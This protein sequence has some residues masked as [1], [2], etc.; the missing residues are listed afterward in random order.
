MIMFSRALASA[1]IVL[2]AAIPAVAQDDV[3]TFNAFAVVTANGTIVR[4]AEKQVMVVAT[5]AGPYFVE[6]DEG[7]QHG[8]R[9][10]C[11]SSAR[12]DQ[13]TRQT[14][15]S[16]ACTFTAHDGATAWGDWDCAGYELIGCRGTFKLT[17]GTGRFAGAS[18][19]SA[20]IWRPTAHEFRKQLDG[21][22]LDNATGIVLW[23]DFKL[24]GK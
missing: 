3:Q 2:A 24:K 20:L 10:S 19:E 23:R 8:G 13:R 18:G 4:S 21:T 6:T 16:G 9:V 11:A 1:V 12:I 14:S 5:L 7:P 15:A 17:G 22:T